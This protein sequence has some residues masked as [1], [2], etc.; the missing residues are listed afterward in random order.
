MRHTDELVKGRLR[1]FAIVMAGV[2]AAWVARSAGSGLV[3]ELP[4]TEPDAIVSLGSHEHERLPMAAQLAQANPRAMLLL[5]RPR[6]VTVHNCED[7][8]HRIDRL[9]DLGVVDARVHVLQL[10]DDSTHGEALVTLAFARAAGI[11]RLM[12]VTSPYHTRRA[13]AA[14]KRVFDGSGVALGVEPARETSPARP[15]R[16]LLGSYDRGYVAYEWIGIAYYMSKYGV[17]FQDVAASDPR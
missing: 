9:R 15:S 11:R 3:V 8:E 10:S 13:L 5:T 16:W 12:I 17:R 1:L 6:E 2:L 4:L 14:F 7:C